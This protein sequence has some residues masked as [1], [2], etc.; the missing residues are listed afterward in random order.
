MA[1]TRCAVVVFKR[2]YCIPVQT[3]SGVRVARMVA[4]WFSLHERLIFQSASKN[5]SL[6]L[7]EELK[8]EVWDSLEADGEALLKSE[9]EQYHCELQENPV[10]FSEG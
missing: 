9:W 6:E 1:A 3:S 5:I 2:V 10:V 7:K 8:C 4:E